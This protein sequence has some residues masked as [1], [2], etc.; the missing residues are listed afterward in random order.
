MARK[1]EVQK[2][3]IIGNP[4]TMK[5]ATHREKLNE[6]GKEMKLRRHGQTLDLVE[7]KSRRR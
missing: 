4:P 2:G 1:V 5:Q 3:M 6:A 7:P